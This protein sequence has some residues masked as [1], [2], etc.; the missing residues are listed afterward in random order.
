MLSQL[1]YLTDFRSQHVCHLL[2][3]AFQDLPD[4][5]NNHLTLFITSYVSIGINLFYKYN[6]FLIW[7]ICQSPFQKWNFPKDRKHELFLTI[8]S[9]ILWDKSRWIQNRCWMN[10][11][12]MNELFKMLLNTESFIAKTMLSQSCF[13]FS[14]VANLLNYIDISKEK[15]IFYFYFSYK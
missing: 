5:S 6:F 9:F 8:L 11:G 13:A 7:L 12:W 4:Q 14:K 2:W 10:I 1:T 15:Y 3:E